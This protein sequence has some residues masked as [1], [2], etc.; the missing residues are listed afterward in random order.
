MT[1]TVSPEEFTLVLFDALALQTT[2]SDLMARLGLSERALRVEVDETTPIVRISV[3]DGDPIV[4]AAGSGAFEDPRVPRH[5][6][7]VHIVTNAG[8]PLLRVRDRNDGSFADAPT[9]DDLTLAQLAAWDA[10]CVGRLGRLGYPV[11]EQRWR[12]NFRNR[13]GFTDVGDAAF[14]R[15]WNA[16]GLTWSELEAI[17]AEAEAAKL[18]A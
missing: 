4:L 9:D 5:Q 16:D 3:Q 14:E 10:Y 13:H 6:S 12:Y 8:R 11:H 2:L 18:P 17:S 1:V 15:L 7:E